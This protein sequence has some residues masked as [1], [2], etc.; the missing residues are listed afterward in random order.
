MTQS[1][2][3]AVPSPATGA[4]AHDVSHENERAGTRQW[5]GL[6]VL[7]LP[8]VLASM[9]MSV[10]FVTLPS[11]TV[12]L[13]P[14]GSE[15]LWI[16]DAYGFL[17]AGLLI[18]MGT[19]GDRIGRRRVLLTGA[20]AF[21]LASTLAAWASSPEMLIATRALMGIAGATLAPSTLALIR[22]LFHDDR[23][24][25]TAVGIWT[26]GFAGGAVVGPI[27]GGLLLEHFWWGSVFLINIPVMALLLCLGPLLLPEFRDPEP[28]S[29]FDLLGALLSLVAVLAVIYGIKTTAEHGIG[30][31][32]A[33]SLL[34]GMTA[35]ALF[36]HRQR[37]TPN[38]M[39]NITLF[40]TRWFNVPLLIDA[41]ATFAMVG[42]SLFNWQFMQLV[43]G[44]SPLKSAL[45]SLPT[46]LVMPVGIAL[47]AG[48]APRVGKPRVMTA[49]LLVAAAGYVGLTLIRPDSGILHLVC[50]LT[51]VSLGIAGVAAIVTDVI[52]S[53]AP[54]ERAGAASSLAETSAEF[55][56]ALGIAILGS[57][58]TAVYRAQMGSSAP[59]NLTP[60]QLASAEATLGGAIDTA[61]TL[62]A[63]AAEA[64]RNAAFDAFI[65]ELR[66]AAALSAVL[67]AGGALLIARTLRP[68][69]TRTADLG[70]APDRGRAP[71]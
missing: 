28:G 37:A 35:G 51:V 10:M 62:P 22:N 41:L 9:D 56:G 23:Q 57:I 3:A 40:R 71:A 24:R 34:A 19:L 33:G 53:A 58:G 39:I 8:C 63:G 29:R 17:L 15:L 52:L 49:G 55:G 12:D 69:R 26:A 43:L 48:M 42:F 45:W 14:S 65:R 59:A 46:F 6:A 36:L 30:W 64:L 13:R 1:V 47:A 66:I 21:G 31:A 5:T 18:T 11:L 20:A 4:G 50:A 32:G 16:M 61:R 68:A 27:V 67:T 44:M 38:P 60:E 2:P 54:P 7:V 70:P 25:A